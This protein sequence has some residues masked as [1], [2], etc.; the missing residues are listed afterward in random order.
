MEKEPVNIHNH[1]GFEINHC[2]MPNAT[3]QTISQSTGNEEHVN[4]EHVNEERKMKNEEF[5]GMKE[6][7]SFGG[8]A[9]MLHTSLKELPAVLDT[10]RARTLLERLVEAGLLDEAWQP[11]GLSGARRGVL[12]QQLA[13]RLGIAH[14]WQTFAPLWGM[15]PETLRAAYNQGMAQKGMADFI[16]RLNKALG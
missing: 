3:F 8:E 11:V 13:A 16:G 5:S 1:F 6:K 14:T 2:N 4:E 7:S 12:A 10:P 9:D 15:K